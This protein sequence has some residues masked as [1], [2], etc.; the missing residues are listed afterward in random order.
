MILDVMSVE[1]GIP[2]SELEKMPLN[3]KGAINDPHDRGGI[4]SIWGWTEKSLLDCKAG[5]TAAE[6]TFKDAYE[7]YAKN[8]YVKS[9]ASLVLPIHPYLAKAMLNFGIHA[10]YKRAAMQLQTLLN[11]HNNNQALWK[12]MVVDGV[13]G[14][15]TIDCLMLYLQ[16]RSGDGDDIL[17]TD[18]LIAV[19]AHYQAIIKADPTQEK[20]MM[21]WSR[22]VHEQ[23]RD[24]FTKKS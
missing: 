10:G 15:G 2:V 24:Y 17:F 16:K 3:K 5:I 4:T 21:G 7:L 18:Y 13:I 12:D 6:L 8:Y 1:S 20:Y 14:K 23:L 22:R 9:G 11:M 19:G